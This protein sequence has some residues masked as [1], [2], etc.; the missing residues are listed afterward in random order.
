MILHLRHCSE[1]AAPAPHGTRDYGPS[2]RLNRERSGHAKQW[3][4]PSQAVL[5]FSHRVSKC[6]FVAREDEQDNDAC[7]KANSDVAKPTEP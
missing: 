2:T 1:A 6:S 5:I 7:C 3:P 4:N